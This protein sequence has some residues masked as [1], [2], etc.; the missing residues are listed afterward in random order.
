LRRTVS[1][2]ATGVAVAAVTPF[3]TYVGGALAQPKLNALLLGLFAG[4][5]VILACVGLFGV[6]ATSV[7]L[8]A[9]ELSVRLALGATPNDLRATVLRPAVAIASAGI[10]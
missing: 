10:A 5:A 1:D 7:R 3:E 8:R 2:V 4:A 6:M 9:R